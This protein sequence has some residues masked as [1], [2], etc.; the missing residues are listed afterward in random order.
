MMYESHLNEAVIEK[1]LKKSSCLN[2]RRFF[3]NT[4]C[5]SETTHDYLDFERK[6]IVPVNLV[7]RVLVTI[8]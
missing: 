6:V 5:F 1:L 8:I 7:N 2:N 4:I 3:K